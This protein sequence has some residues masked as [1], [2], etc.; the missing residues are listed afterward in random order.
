L[1]L[2]WLRLVQDL[3]PGLSLSR[4][5]LGVRVLAD[6]QALFGVALIGAGVAFIG[7]G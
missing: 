2:S 1:R 5:G 4:L 7:H 6:R 3:S